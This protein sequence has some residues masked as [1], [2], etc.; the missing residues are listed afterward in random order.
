MGSGLPPHYI[1][2]IN[3]P[4]LSLT[5][6]MSPVDGAGWTSPR[7]TTENW[8][9]PLSQRRNSML[10]PW[11]STSTRRASGRDVFLQR[12]FRASIVQCSCMH[13]STQETRSIFV[14]QHPPPKMDHHACGGA[15]VAGGSCS[16]LVVGTKVQK[17]DLSTSSHGC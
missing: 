1:S 2:Q 6:Q 12:Y 13:L 5:G 14:P 7:P 16:F 15:D 10:S 17:M 9:R 8:A 11:S 4:P 3:S